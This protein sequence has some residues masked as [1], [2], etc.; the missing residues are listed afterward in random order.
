[1]DLLPEDVPY[2]RILLLQ[3]RVQLL[4]APEAF[5][6]TARHPLAL[7]LALCCPWLCVG[8][9]RLLME[10]LAHLPDHSRI[11]LDLQRATDNYLVLRLHQHPACSRI[12]IKALAEANSGLFM[13]L[14]LLRL[15]PRFN[16]IIILD[17][18]VLVH[19]CNF[20]WLEAISRNN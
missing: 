17:F 7:T 14:G 9:P 16:L 5:G 15:Q 2:D 12:Q 1:M 18:F 6:R 4:I 8:C 10:R 11:S 3:V 20:V 13:V 19:F